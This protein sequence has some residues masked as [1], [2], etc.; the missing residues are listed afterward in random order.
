[1]TTVATRSDPA[2]FVDDAKNASA[3]DAKPEVAS[4][5]A[6]TELERERFLVATAS[7]EVAAALCATYP[8]LIRPIALMI[9]MFSGTPSHAHRAHARARVVAVLG[10]GLGRL[11]RVGAH[12]EA[13]GEWK[14]AYRDYERSVA[15]G[16][17]DNLDAR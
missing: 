15:I 12:H 9:A 17:S 8:T 13:R 5:N 14:Q 10:F 1:M 4:P 3:A 2:C 11:D 16:E 7:E 6:S